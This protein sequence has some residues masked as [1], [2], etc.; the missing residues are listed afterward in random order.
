[1]GALRARLSVLE[2]AAEEAR[3]LRRS[4]DEAD[5]LRTSL[6]SAQ[7]DIERLLEDKRTLL[8]E[9]RRM[10]DQMGVQQASHVSQTASN[11]R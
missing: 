2:R 7:N 10:R 5:A 8:D 4:R 1:M 3:S 11:K 6:A 9:L